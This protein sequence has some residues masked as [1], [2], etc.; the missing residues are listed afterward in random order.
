MDKKRRNIRKRM[1]N[2]LRKRKIAKKMEKDDGKIIVM[3]K[4]R[5]LLFGY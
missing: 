1:R 3:V 4:N 2:R 5:M